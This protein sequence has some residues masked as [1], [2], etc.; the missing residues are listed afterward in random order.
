MDFVTHFPILVN[1][2]GHA[3]GIAAF[4][5]FLVLLFRS[6]RP[7]IRLPAAAAGLALSW[8]LGSLVGLLSE[9]DSQFREAVATLSLAILSLVPCTLL[10][11]ALG[12]QH[13][14]LSRSGYALSGFAAAIHFSNAV[15]VRV[16]WQAAGTAAI[17]YGFSALAVTSA[18]LLAIRGS[19][20]RRTGMRALAA[21]ALFLLAGSFVHFGREHA[22]GAWVHE[23]VFHHAG[24]P[25]ALFVLL[26]DYRFLL[27]DVFVRLAGAGLL[28][29]AFAGTLLWL[30]DS[31]ALL[32]NASATA[33]GLAVFVVVSGLVIVAYPVILQGAGRRLENALFGR[34]NVGEASRTVR[35]LEADS[36]TALLVQASRCLAEFVSAERWEL[37]AT[38]V[39]IQAA[40]SEAAPAPVFDILTA[41]GH[42]WPEAV[43]ALRDG[44]GTSRPLL[45]GS[46]E[47]GR[48][49]LSVDLAD[50][51]IL[52]AEVN[53]RVERMRREEQD[54]LL[55]EAEMATLRAQINPHFLFNALNALNGI[56]PADAADARRTLVNLAD[57]FRYSL[58]SKR[59]FVPLE[60]ELEI[61]RA[62]LQI[63]RLRLGARLS[64]RIDMGEEARYRK[65]PAL[66]IQPLV[67]NAVKHGVSRKVEGGEVRVSARQEDSRLRIDV[68]D[69]GPGFDAATASTVGHG[70]LNVERR[71]HLCYGGDVEFVI[72][73]GQSGSRVG[74]SVP[75]RESE[76]P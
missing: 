18:V 51:D 69:D 6:R 42:P 66:S 52:A 22:A 50:L 76:R 46:R 20:H 2:L 3:A 11:L 34:K 27:M 14:W 19:S 17:Y 24:I 26:Q 30:A 54:N 47:G 35:A 53:S 49:Y 38:A 73:S 7:G 68:A 60:E 15:G 41:S 72:E 62:Y 55:R 40:R 61:V 65:V 25:L 8:N 45:L 64:S 63:E 48:R 28:A 36:D 1:V 58:E 5:A 56:I 32:E 59:Q 74:F 33:I 16:G 29:G 10:H 21:M 39:D 70:L 13:R 12:E 23:L 43:V 67:E 9:Q 57:I 31:L 75:L 37:L 44:A 4:G 71:L